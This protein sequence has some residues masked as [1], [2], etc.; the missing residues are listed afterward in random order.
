MSKVINLF[1]F[2][3]FLILSLNFI[4]AVSI[5]P[6]EQ[7]TFAE[8]YQTCNNCTYCNITT[9]TNPN[10]T[11]LL[12]NTE[13]TNNTPSYFFHILNESNTTSL[14]SYKY[15][16]DC[17]NPAQSETGCIDFEV[18]PDGFATDLSKMWVN[19][20]FLIFFIGLIAGTHH[21][22]KKVNF[23]KWND[24]IMQKYIDRNLVKVV[25]SALLYNIMKNIYI[26]YYL[27][28]LP[29]FLILMDMA[30]VYNISVIIT[31]MIVFFY[32]YI[33]IGIPIVGI[34]FFS[35]VQE[36]FKE[37]MELVENADWGIEM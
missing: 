16:F 33:G 4:S 10:G 12:S 31:P 37:M 8:L 21:L 14:G 22:V 32:I 26:I 23:K 17:G 6:V 19:I 25:L 28:G 20:F 9:V 35:Y 5:E 2:A 27:M 36:W 30:R 1:S 29:I 15:C 11:I 24:S 7:G 13:F 18:T 34:V 3:F